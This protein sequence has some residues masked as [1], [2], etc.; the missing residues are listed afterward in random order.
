MEGE[1][2]VTVERYQMFVGGKK[3]DAADGE[4]Q[5]VINPATGETIAAVPRGSE[6]D[7]D[8]AVDAA[9]KAFESWG[10]L[11]P[12][13]RSLPLLR[14]ADRLEEHGEELAQLESLN[15]GK[16]IKHARDEIGFAA[17]NMRFFAGAARCLEGRAAGEYL[18]GYT[19]IIRRDPIGVVGAL[20]PWNNP[21]M[22]GVWDICPGIK[23]GKTR[24]L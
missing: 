1:M 9:E 22:F 16:P 12:G 23:G 6:R 4:M 3:I 8:R 17:D 10:Q 19:S 15:V 11:S 20:A 5:S 21:M 13:E 7:V 18:R 2:S 24:V 14:L